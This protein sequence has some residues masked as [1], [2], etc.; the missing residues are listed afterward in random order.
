MSWKTEDIKQ[1]ALPRSPSKQKSTTTK[2]KAIDKGNNTNMVLP[3]M[4]SNLKNT[5]NKMDDKITQF[6]KRYEEEQ[7]SIVTEINKEAIIAPIA[8]E[9]IKR[10]IK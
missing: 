7:A 6:A 4:H 1:R 8:S 5:I 9:N 2:Q 3:E 10:V